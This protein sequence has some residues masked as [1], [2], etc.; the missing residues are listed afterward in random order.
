MKVNFNICFWEFKDFENRLRNTK[1]SWQMMK[2][3][4]EFCKTKGLDFSCYL[5]DFSKNK[6][7][8]D[9]IHLPL[10][11]I[12]YE[13]SKKL[14]LAIEWNFINDK[15]EYVCFLDADVFFL[16][17]EYEAIILQILELNSNEFITS[18]VYDFP[19]NESV[20]F[21]KNLLIDIPQ[22]TIRDIPGLGAFFFVD[23]STLIETGAFDERFIVWGGE[24]DDL[25]MRLEKKGLRRK[26]LKSK[27]YHLYHPTLIDHANIENNHIKQEQLKCWNDPNINRDTILK[28][29]NI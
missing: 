6:N 17:N 11:E 16:K 21:E 2:E 12:S 8:N 20:D 3:F 27:L 7:F 10:S 13:R 14:N 4:I 28:K 26:T 23:M 19:N 5:F 29:Y 24:D 9:G 18:G 22:T 15:P 1:F 25:K